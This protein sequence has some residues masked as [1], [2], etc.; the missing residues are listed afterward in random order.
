MT[1]SSVHQF[2]PL[3][4]P[5]WAEFIERHPRASVFHAPEWLE[6]LRRTYGYEP[7][8]L[9]TS[10]PGEK[11]G[12]A[13]VY[14]RVQSWLTGRRLVSLPFSD[15]CEPL[16]ERP[17]E[18]DHLVS[19]L[20]REREEG[21][22]KYLEIRPV[23]MPEKVPDRLDKSQ[24]FCFHRLALHDSPEKLFRSFHKDCVQRKIRR[25]E[26]EGLVCEDGRSETLLL[27][28][29]QL[30]V[31]TRRRQ[32]LPP[33]PLD[34][35]RNLIACLGDRLRIWVASKGDRAVASILTLRHNGTLV[36]K[37][38]CSDKAFSNLG[39]MHLLFWRA[40]EKAKGDGLLE[41]DLGRSD[42]DNPGLIDFKDRWGAARS[43]LGYLRYPGGLARP[44]TNHW[45]TQIARRVVARAPDSLMT[46]AG[47]VLYR[48]LG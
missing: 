34:W 17:E 23:T 38:G 48:H 8:A 45:G 16:V 18:M 43:E 47:R 26:R 22:W 2:S 46:A 1:T 15:H 44:G 4:D 29:Y 21:H 35:F 33:Q 20:A 39:G 30:L 14:C 6:S 36:Y 42:W 12:N 31:L 5:R 10:G 11:L 3:Q 9:T 40:I 24:T 19:A 13:I 7:A 28:F 37:Y 41:F 32:Q 27:T 25:G